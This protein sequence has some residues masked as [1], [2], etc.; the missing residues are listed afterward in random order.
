M[1][2]GGFSS[3]S[4]LYL[5]RSRRKPFFDG[6]G[7]GESR[8]VTGFSHKNEEFCQ[9]VSLEFPSLSKGFISAHLDVEEHRDFTQ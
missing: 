5:P 8:V 1:R 7:E 6:G 9:A 4:I 3:L 2:K